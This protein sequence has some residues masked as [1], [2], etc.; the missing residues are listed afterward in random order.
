LRG[1]GSFRS[2]SLSKGALFKFIALLPAL[3][4]ILASPAYSSLGLTVGLEDGWVWQVVLLPPEDGWESDSGSSAL[5]AVRLAEWRVMDSADGVCGRDI[6]FHQEPAVDAKTATERVADWR[7]RGISAV[8]SFSQG[9]DIITL[10]PHL[11]GGGPLLLSAFGEE[12]GFLDE[13]GVPE[14]MIFALDMF[15]DFRISA[16]SAYASY[17]LPAGSVVAI[18]ADRLDPML[19]RCSRNLGDMLSDS[20]FTVES[21]WISGG[22]TDS[23]RMVESEAISSGARVMVTWAGSMAI[24]DIW[25][26]TRRRAD[27]FEIWYGSAPHRLLLSFDGVIVADQDHPVK[28]DDSLNSLRREIRERFNIVVKNNDIAGRAYAACEWL[29]DAFQRAGSPVPSVL[30]GVMPEV[31]GLSLGSQELRIDPATHRP[32][33]RRVTFMTVSEKLFHPVKSLVVK[34]QEYLP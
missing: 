3:L 6:R 2:F 7:K 25:R 27:G 11:S 32:A 13:K 18:L 17:T 34:G 5:A 33:E 26:A 19:E 31:S 9:D 28:T 14:T 1:T 22:G 15:R 29:L 10:R 20:E 16:F 21:Y 8:I 12:A 4:F 24:R 30:A 23:F